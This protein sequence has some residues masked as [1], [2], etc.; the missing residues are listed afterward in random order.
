MKKIAINTDSI[1]LGQFLKWADLA[2]TGGEA[3][4][5]IKKGNVIVNGEI[6]KRRSTTLSSADIVEVAGA[7]Y[8]IIVNS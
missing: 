8:Q 2:S 3:K 5:M 6:E 1:E 7:K 4:S